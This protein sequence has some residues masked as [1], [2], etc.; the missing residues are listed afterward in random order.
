VTLCA[1]CTVHIETRRADFLV[2]LKNQGRRFVSGLASKPLERS[3]LASKSVATVFPS[4]ISKPVV[5]VSLG[6][7]SK[8][9]CVF[10]LSLKTKMVEGFSV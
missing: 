6:L 9:W 5:T 10:W 4:L 2:E 7:T 3:D 1:V 8:R